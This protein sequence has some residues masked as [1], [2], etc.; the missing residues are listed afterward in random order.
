MVFL[1]HSALAACPQPLI[2]W[3][4]VFKLLKFDHT[5]KKKKNKVKAVY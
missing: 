1:M 2:Y 5:P 3:S 4:G